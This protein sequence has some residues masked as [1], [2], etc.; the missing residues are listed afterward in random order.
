MNSAMNMKSCDF[1]YF[2]DTVV[3]DGE[4]SGKDSNYGNNNF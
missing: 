3:E 2:C 1:M 4:R